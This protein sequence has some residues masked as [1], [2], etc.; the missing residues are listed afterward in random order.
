MRTTFGHEFHKPKQE[1]MSASAYL[2]KYLICELQQKEYHACMM[3]LRHM[4]AVLCEMF[5]VTA[6]MTEGQME[7]DH[8]M[9]FTLARFQ[10][11]GFLPVGTPTD[12]VDNE[13]ALHRI[14]VAC[15]TISNCPGN[16]ER[17]RR[18]MMRRVEAFIESHG[19][20]F[21]HLL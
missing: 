16:F 9:A 15:Q 18:S 8:C 2:W 20:H 6:V 10:S 11:S 1:N 17:M 19:G 12:P 4:L 3:V 14:V 7:E 13:E 21:V 5:S